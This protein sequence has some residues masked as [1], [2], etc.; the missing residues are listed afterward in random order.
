[1]EDSNLTFVKYFVRIYM[2]YLP[3]GVRLQQA[4][5]IHYYKNKNMIKKYFIICSI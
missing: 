4:I 5:N 2:I 3:D 1:M